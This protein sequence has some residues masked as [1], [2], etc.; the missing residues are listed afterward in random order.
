MHDR[1][2]NTGHVG[3]MVTPPSVPDDGTL[4]PIRRLMDEECDD[5]E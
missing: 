5:A 2:Y 3:C 1:V 4:H